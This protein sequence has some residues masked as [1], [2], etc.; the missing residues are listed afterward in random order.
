MS[1]EVFVSQ[2]SNLLLL[3]PGINLLLGLGAFFSRKKFKKTSSLVAIFAIATFVLSSLSVIATK[4]TMSLQTD[5]YLS[6]KQIK[7]FEKQQREDIAIVILAGGRRSS[8]PEY[9]EIDT[10]SRMTLQ[11][12]QYGAW[13]HRK[14]KIPLLLSGGSVNGEATAE[15]VLMNQTMLSAF[16]IPPKWIETESKNTAENAQFS[17]KILKEN[18]ITN[19]LLVTHA[20][21]MHRAKIEFEKTGLM[22]IPAPTVFESESDNWQDYLPSAKALYESHSAL[23]EKLGRLWY[24]LR[25]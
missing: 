1:F 20:S 17:A 21:H 14:L 10:V 23:H 19:V 16:N 12:L 13:L 22:I 24:S 11:R 15:S 8:A 9:G 25:Y 3:P 18:S 2:L 5:T 4:L 7:T 6:L